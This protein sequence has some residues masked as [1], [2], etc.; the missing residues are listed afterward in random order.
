MFIS[1]YDIST[2]K[3]S[4]IEAALMQ[5]AQLRYVCAAVIALMGAVLFSAS[6]LVTAIVIGN[7][8]HATNATV[9]PKPT[10]ENQPHA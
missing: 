8:G 3:T 10:I 5:V 1:G 4:V 9:S 2:Y 7:G 6:Q